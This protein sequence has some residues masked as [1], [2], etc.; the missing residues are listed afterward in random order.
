M[1]L[2]L[3]EE[4]DIN[5]EIY[6]CGCSLHLNKKNRE[7]YISAYYKEIYKISN[8]YERIVGIET[9]VDLSESLFEILL[10]EENIR[11]SEVEFNNLLN[12]KL[13]NPL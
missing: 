5:G 11:L 8:C 6:P 2:Q 13:I 10:N 7:E 3:W 12:L 1:I 4:S 9:E